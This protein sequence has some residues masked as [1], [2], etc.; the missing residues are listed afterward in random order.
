MSGCI[1]IKRSII[2]H[3]RRKNDSGHTRYSFAEDFFKGAVEIAPVYYI[4]GNHEQWLKGEKFDRFLTEIQGMG[5][6]LRE[7]AWL[8]MR[9]TI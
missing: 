8:Q 7:A 4:T 5:V 1:R 2:A 3:I 6:T 9:M